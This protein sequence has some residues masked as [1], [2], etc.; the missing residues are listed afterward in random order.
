MV[1]ETDNKDKNESR[2]IHQIN[3]PIFNRGNLGK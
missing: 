1:G 2:K 3:C